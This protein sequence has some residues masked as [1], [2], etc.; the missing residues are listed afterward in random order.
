MPITTRILHHRAIHLAQYIIM[1]L[2]S[3]RVKN[4]SKFS[5]SKKFSSK[6]VWLRK[7]IL[8]AKVEMI[9]PIKVPITVT[10]LRPISQRK[11]KYD[12]FKD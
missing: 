11:L 6:F 1:H 10:I 4:G 8:R 2:P 12:K 3:I 9:V 7:Y 5:M